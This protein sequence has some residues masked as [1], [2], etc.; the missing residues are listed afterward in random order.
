[1]QWARQQQYLCTQR[2]RLRMCE[3]ENTCT[4]QL[5]SWQSV[6][7]VMIYMYIAW[8]IVTRWCTFLDWMLLCTEFSRMWSS[9]SSAIMQLLPHMQAWALVY[10]LMSAQRLDSV[11]MYQYVIPQ[12]IY[13]I[14]IYT[15]TYTH[16][17]SVNFSPWAFIRKGKVRWPKLS[18]CSN[19]VP[20]RE[21]RVEG[22]RN[23]W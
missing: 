4:L 2:I 7:V 9:Y 1:M 6:V 21:W 16:L 3:Q 22:G 12:V 15:Y 19:T 11:C 5:H 23:G 17:P 20:F 13:C 18:R 10:W 14:Y 8:R